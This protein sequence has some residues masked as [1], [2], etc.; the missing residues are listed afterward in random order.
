MVEEVIRLLEEEQQPFLPGKVA[1]VV[2][3]Y[4]LEVEDLDGLSRQVLAEGVRR[5][6]PAVE[7]FF[8]TLKIP[9]PLE[10]IEEA[11]WK[12][13]GVSVYPPNPQ[14][15]GKNFTVV[16]DDPTSKGPDRPSG[17]KLTFPPS[18]WHEPLYGSMSF[19]ALPGEVSLRDH[20]HGVYLGREKAMLIVRG[21]EVVK[22]IEQDFT[23]IS[24]SW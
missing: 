1:Q 10:K 8:E 2:R 6:M 23:H 4:G 13:G 20:F 19:H 18:W 22:R 7:K 9:A 14:V 21:E 17:E 3:D 5:T 16:I 15:G 12:G 24:V 11:L